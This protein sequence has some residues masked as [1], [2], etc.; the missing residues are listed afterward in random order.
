MHSEQH[1]SLAL[2]AS[3]K[4]PQAFYPSDLKTLSTVRLVSFSFKHV[5]VTENECKKKIL[6]I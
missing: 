1:P 2:R 3:P 6:L 4:G 5:M